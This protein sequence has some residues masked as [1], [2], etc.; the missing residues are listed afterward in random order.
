MKISIYSFWTRNTSFREN[1]IAPSNFIRTN[2]TGD[3]TV[4][5]RLISFKFRSLLFVKNYCCE[6]RYLLVPTASTRAFPY[7]S[8]SRC[9]F[10]DP[11]Y[12]FVRH[13]VSTLPRKDRCRSETS[14]F[15]LAR[16]VS[17]KL[18]SEFWRSLAAY[19]VF[20]PRKNLFVEHPIKQTKRYNMYKMHVDG[21]L[22]SLVN[23]HH[24]SYRFWN[25]FNC[26]WNATK[27]VDARET[28]MFLE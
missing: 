15:R 27:N 28:L 6:S 19:R 22:A 18:D 21:R 7:V 17:S 20:L 10:Y 9:F 12:V 26:S 14:N 1:L 2:Y 4:D 24:D 8:L 11:E 5:S 16:S 13:R 23:T 3:R 25:E